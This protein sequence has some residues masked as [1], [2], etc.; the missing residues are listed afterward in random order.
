MSAHRTSTTAHLLPLDKKGGDQKINES[1]FWLT[2][3]IDI[4]H[5]LPTRVLNNSGT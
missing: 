2:R 3:T 5:I 1:E 4:A